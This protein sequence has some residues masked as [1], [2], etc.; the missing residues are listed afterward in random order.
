MSQ[1]QTKSTKGEIKMREEVIAI[2]KYKHSD[3][4]TSEIRYTL[5]SCTV[6]KQNGESVVI[7]KSISGKDFQ[8]F[9]HMY[10]YLHNLIIDNNFKLT[11]LTE[12][13]ARVY[14]IYWCNINTTLPPFTSYLSHDFWVKLHK[15]V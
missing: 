4:L 9:H 1:H 15:L 2:A 13:N 6:A 12:F 3:E 14:S 10:I 5:Y 8:T 11:C 7:M